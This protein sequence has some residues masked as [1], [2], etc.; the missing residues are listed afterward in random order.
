MERLI[1]NKL[2]LYLGKTEFNVFCSK[3]KVRKVDKEL[4]G[5]HKGVVIKRYKMCQIHWI[6][7]RTKS[8]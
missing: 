1:D 4:L 5:E 7:S 2:P 6:K 8:E 3:H